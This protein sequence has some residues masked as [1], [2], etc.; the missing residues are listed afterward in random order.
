[1]K[2]KM[3][4]VATPDIQPNNDTGD[5]KTGLSHPRA[6]RGAL[7]AGLGILIA[8]GCMRAPTTSP[9]FAT[10]IT[11][12]EIASLP[13]TATP[14]AEAI[15]TITTPF[16]QELEDFFASI[17]LVFADLKP[18]FLG[19]KYKVPRNTTFYRSPSTD[20]V[21]GS[22]N[23]GDI[24]LFAPVKVTSGGKNFITFIHEDTRVFVLEANC[25]P[26]EGEGQ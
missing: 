22:A 11:E 18:Q 15:A 5:R 9:P 26:I 21:C 2:K 20:D 25:D 16:Y 1:M 17:G 19:G 10:A 8:A 14:T 6:L 13:S 24:D 12:T 7:L 23:G 3:S 4:T